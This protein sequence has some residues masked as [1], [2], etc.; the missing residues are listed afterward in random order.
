PAE[1]SGTSRNTYLFVNRRFVKDRGILQALAMG[2]GEI[3]ERGRYPLAV[4]HV[5]V[6]GE[7]LDVNVHPQK[8][9]LRFSR[10]QEVFA[11]VRHAVARAVATAPWLTE[12]AG[13]QVAPYSM[14]PRLPVSGGGGGWSGGGGWLRAPSGRGHVPEE[15]SADALSL[16]APAPA[17]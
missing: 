3:L 6:R 7:T 5:T 13:A 10:P 2:Y 12:P 16:F 17:L 11:A 8:L 9:E 14:E 15:R 1:S 4:V